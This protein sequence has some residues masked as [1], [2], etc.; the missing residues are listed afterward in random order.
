MLPQSPLAASLP[1]LA[2]RRATPADV[3]AFSAFGRRVAIET[4]ATQ[5]DPSDFAMYLAATFGPAQQSAEIADPAGAVLLAEA[6]GEL[7]GYVYVR[8]VPAPECVEGRQPVEIA[9]LYVA[10]AWHGR[11][12]ARA[13]MAAAATEARRRGGHTLW[14]GV[15]ERNPRAIAFYT[16]CGFRDVGSH[17]FMIGTDAQ[18]DR[19]MA[20]PVEAVARHTAPSADRAEPAG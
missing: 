18:T 1:D 7:A 15:W 2:I 9:R 5:N 12:V 3:D 16:K 14:L 4:F 17:V 6:A 20:A 11:G 8:A 10:A 19:L 13:L